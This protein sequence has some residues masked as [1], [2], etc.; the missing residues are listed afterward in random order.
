MTNALTIFLSR[1]ADLPSY[2][3]VDLGQQNMMGAQHFMTSLFRVMNGHGMAI[4]NGGERLLHDLTVRGD[5]QNVM[6][7]D[8]LRKLFGEAINLSKRAFLDGLGKRRLGFRTSVKDGGIW[9]DCLATRGIDTNTLEPFRNG[10]IF[11]IFKNQNRSTH[12]IENTKNGVR[13]K[14]RLK[15]KMNNGAWVDAYQVQSGKFENLNL[16]FTYESIP[17]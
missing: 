17:H 9:Y 4:H 16:I 1:C 7:W 3:V 12:V 11:L 15:Y 5:V 13:I 14:A 10:P 2:A 6:G 8:H